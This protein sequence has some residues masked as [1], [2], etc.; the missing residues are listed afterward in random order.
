LQG[1][2]LILEIISE[3]LNFLEKNNIR[4]KKQL[5]IKLQGLIQGL[6]FRPFIYHL[7]TKYQ[8]NGWVANTNNGITLVIE[9]DSLQ[10][11]LFLFALQHQL[12]PFAKID[13]ISIQSQTPSNFN[14]FEIKPSSITGQKSAFILPDISPCTHCISD[15]LNPESRFYRYAF[16]SCCY[17]GPRYS[18]MK[19]QPYDR[20]R[21]SM[22][23][24][25]PCS[26]CHADYQNPK[27]RRFHSQTIACPD[28]GPQLTLINNKTNL[29]L[30]SPLLTVIKLLKQGE[31]IA[32]KGVGG[33][34]L[35]VDANNNQ[36]I[37][38]LR[39]K[40]Q[41]PYK[42]FA[43]LVNNIAEAQL[44]CQI[45]TSEQQSLSS[46]ASPIVLLKRLQ[47][48]KISKSVAADTNLL[49]IMLPASPLHYLIANDF[50]QPLVITSGNK[51]HEP[52]CINDEQ[53]LE[54]LSH[55][56]DYF[57]T[58]TRDIIRPLD[59]SLVRV[60][61]NHE[62]VLRRARGYTPLPIMT[63]KISNETLAVGGHLKNT[64]GISLG[65]Q[66]ILS[67]HLGDLESLASQRLFQQ[68]LIDLQQFYSIAPTTIV[69]D[70]HPDYHS[71]QA[72]QTQ[73]L[74]KQA[75]QHHHAHILACMAE[76]NLSPPLLGFAWDGTGLG[77]DNTFWGGES[78]LITAHGFHRLAHFK[79]FSLVGG[80]K[81]ATEPRRSALGLLYNLYDN[82]LFN[83]NFEFLSE[84]STLE[85]KLLQQSLNKQLN[86]HKTS[87]VGRI[88]DALSSILGLCHINQFEG[89]AAI[90]LEQLAETVNSEQC[91]PV[92]LEGDNPIVIEWQSL[93]ISLLADLNQ[94]NKAEIARKFHN[95]LAEIILQISQ[96]QQQQ[97]QTIVLTGGCF[98]NAL[99]TEIC[100]KKLTNAGFS[101]YTHQKIPPNDGGLALGQLYA[102]NLDSF[103]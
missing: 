6:G 58:H 51:S 16:T 52:L 32:L 96:K 49:G 85:L 103:K 24:F 53:A 72:A 30:N 20:I 56:T 80:N 3:P 5:L 76:H 87:S 61:N 33:F 67:Q 28:C 46:Y 99:L 1:I 22:E 7:A 90:L 70:L 44:L 21:T 42:P 47:N 83:K 29:S 17:C 94:L 89:Q 92:S 23:N 74:K 65:N 54:Q 10:H 86:T 26:C 37:E 11:D 75:I 68:T 81:S 93:F 82:D 41:R 35:I 79:T 4:V 66:L 15:I 38:R 50:Q 98:Q 55:I 8:Q 59:D 57:L 12:P 13:S 34:Q 14:N 91:Y 88:F 77:L 36:A 84:F 63:K 69:H 40:K 60:I 25:S 18:I 64:V 73:P 71:T 101:V 39:L 43:L 45:K 19:Q 48:C 100:I 2:L 9:G 95:T 31:I 78:L 97:K 62:S 102:V 27:D